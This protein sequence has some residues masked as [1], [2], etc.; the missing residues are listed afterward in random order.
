MGAAT[1]EKDANR[2]NMV[3]RSLI[4]T[5]NNNRVKKAIEKARQGREVTIVYL[6]GSITEGHS[7]GPE[8]NYA[9]LSCDCFSRAYGTGHNVKFV[10]AGMSGT[11]SLLGLIRVER[12]VLQ[13]EPDIVFVEFAVNDSRDTTSM[14]AF[15]SLLARLFGSETHPAVVLLFTVMETGY[16][17]QNEMEQIGERFDIPMIS[18]KDA[19]MM[20]IQAGK[21]TWQ[22][23]SNDSTHPDLNGHEL[24]AEFIKYYY[25][26]V[27]REEE[28]AES[29]LPQSFVY[30][31]EFRGMKMLDAVDAP[32]LSLGGFEKANTISQFPN[33]WTHRADASDESYVLELDCKNLF[34]VYKESQ[35]PRTGA[36]DLRVD[37]ELAL[38]ADGYMSSGWNNPV[39]K[40]VLNKESAN[41]R[42]VDIRMAEG[43]KHKEFSILA[44]GYCL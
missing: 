12:D 13:Y 14:K 22:D 11:N 27:D 44:F 10:N 26:T 33:G 23:Y 1:S 41:R 3:E 8:R 24:I 7:A 28:D 6:G 2:M 18:V 21:M 34:I 36:I 16:S 40:M 29:R 43:S 38:T 19:V 25:A 39:T 5:G 15:E 32:V 9:R 35:E 42:K 17:A 20:E 30:G 37:G 4:G 31:D